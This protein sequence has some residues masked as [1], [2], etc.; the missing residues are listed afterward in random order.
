MEN[1]NLISC[2]PSL[3]PDLLCRKWPV[4]HPY[5]GD[6]VY[7]PSL[8]DSTQQSPVP[9]YDLVYL[10]QDVCLALDWLPVLLLATDN[11]CTPT[12]GQAWSAVNCETGE[13]KVFLFSGAQQP[14]AADFIRIEGDCECWKVQSQS[15]GAVQQITTYTAYQDC[16]DCLT[17]RDNESCPT[18]ERTLSFATRLALP[19][20]VQP[21][22]G[23]LECCYRQVVLADLTDSSSYKN[24]FTGFYFKRPTANSTVIFTLLNVDTGV[25]YLINDDTYGIYQAFNNAVQPDLSFIII[26]WQK[27]LNLLGEGA[28]RIEKEITIAGQTATYPSNTLNLKAFSIDEADLT[29]RIDAMQDGNFTR[30]GV[31]FH[32]TGFKTS[33]RLDGFFG[34][35]EREYTQTKLVRSD[36][37]NSNIN[38]RIDYTYTFQ[39]TNLPECI[40]EHLMDFVVVGSTVKI[41]DYNKNNHSYNIIETEVD[42]IENQG[43]EYESLTRKATFNLS[44]SERDKNQRIINCR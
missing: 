3:Y 25:D 37:K 34:R 15:N 35:K 9:T 8:I 11:S 43:T 36:Y 29:V 26:E 14:T 21:D 10:G 19:Q 2:N 27:V 17:A 40:S 23:F 28:Y 12:N 42:L 33:L 6:L 4:R 5:E 1:Y 32:G 38:T 7:I 31:D 13:N 44:F 20:P 41:S 30:E 24:D 39:A 18:A 16:A 22:R